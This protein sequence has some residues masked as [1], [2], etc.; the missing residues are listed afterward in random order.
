VGPQRARLPSGHTVTLYELVCMGARPGFVSRVVEAGFHQRAIR[1]VAHG[2]VDAAA[3]DSQVLA[4]E[5]A[6]VPGWP[7]P[8]G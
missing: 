2:Q 5:P 8:C 6:T 1:L 3:I 7:P 4:V